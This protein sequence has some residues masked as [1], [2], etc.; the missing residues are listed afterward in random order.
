MTSTWA[1]DH[2]DDVHV[3]VAATDTAGLA[4]GPAHTLRQTAFNEIEN[5]LEVLECTLTDDQQRNR[6]D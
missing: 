2:I 6:N 3:L 1:F 5:D 4:T